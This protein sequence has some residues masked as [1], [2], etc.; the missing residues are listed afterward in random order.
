MISIIITSYK[1]AATVGRS[2]QAFLNQNIKEKYELIV[3]APDEETLNVARQYAKK[4]SKVRI[5][6]DPGKGKPAA[7]NLVV[8]KA[9]G[10]ILIL[11]DGDVYVGS[12]SINLIL[13]KFKDPKVGIVSG[14]PV[15]VN[16]RYTMLGFWSHLLTD[17]A[18]K[19]RK[20]R[21]KNNE[22]IVC[23]GY[24]Y[25]FRKKLFKQI[26]ENALSEDAVLSHTI[27]DQRF[28]TA[29]SPASLVYVKYP[30]N[31]ND[32]IKQKKRSAGGYNQL[33]TMVSGKERM[34]SFSKESLGIFKVLSYP[35]SLK[36][37]SYTSILILARIYL[38]ILIY[39]DINI[40]KKEFK[41]IWVR[42]DST[43]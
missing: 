8:K 13:E 20:Q 16:S 38:W 12:N 9:K 25:A 11:S 36:E 3:T 29:Y 6:K 22:M 43:K 2:I 39:I 28:K 40:K 7:L 32:W 10:N 37:L 15:S 17:T 23:S 30:D 4:S 31:F 18:D 42:V 14:R 41:K 5:F 34:R 27:S 19:L 26:P 35:K 24:L 33:K 1:E 21:I